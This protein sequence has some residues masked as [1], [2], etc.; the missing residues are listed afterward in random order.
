MR[1]SVGCRTAVL[2]ALVV[3]TFAGRC[4]HL[5]C[6]LKP[7]CNAW[8]IAPLLFSGNEDFK[9]GKWKEAIE[10]YTKAIDIDPDNKVCTIFIHPPAATRFASLS[11]AQPG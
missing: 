10:G 2:A 6:R 9:T 5:P 7:Y 4:V 1:V 8:Y 3:S 11:Q